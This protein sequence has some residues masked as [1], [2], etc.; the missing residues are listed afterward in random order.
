MHQKTVADDRDGWKR[1]GD[2]EFVY[3]EQRIGVS[4]ITGDSKQTVITMD[5]RHYPAAAPWDPTTGVELPTYIQNSYELLDQP[6]DWYLDHAAETLYYIPR[7]AESMKTATVVVPILQTLVQGSGTLD[8]PIHDI[9]FKGLA[10][11]FGGWTAPTT[12][13]V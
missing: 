2:L 10:F 11:E 5:P 7:P 9:Q 6:G 13:P 12:A 1:P 4:R 3:D 8:S